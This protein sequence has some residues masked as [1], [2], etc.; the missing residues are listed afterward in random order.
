MN[1]KPVTIALLMIC[2]IAGSKMAQAEADWS[3][4]TWDN[5]IF[6]GTDNSYTNGFF[7]AWYDTP[8]NS[9]PEPGYLAR[10]MLWSLPEDAHQLAISAKTIGQTMTTPEDITV[11]DPPPDSV[12][13][14]GL[15]FYTDSYIAIQQG[16]ADR[17]A[18]TIGVVGPLSGAEESQKLVHQITGSDEPQGWDTQLENELVFQFSRAR[19]RRAWVSDNDSADFLLGSA[20][21]LGTIQSYAGVSALLRSGTQLKRTYATSLLATARTANPVAV[22]GG[23]YSFAGVGSKYVFNQITTDGN[24]YRDSR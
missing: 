2:A 9:K 19:I 11:P 15:L 12:P 3:S 7:F 24:T 4:F 17:I 8:L 13:Y 5:D 6:I 16:Y 14:R 18:T 20:A 10:A 22:E 1:I 21:A 23:W